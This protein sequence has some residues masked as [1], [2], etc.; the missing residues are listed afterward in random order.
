MMENYD[1][2]YWS[3]PCP[4]VDC[5]RK[6][7][8]CGLEYVFLPAVLGDDSEDSKVAPKKGDYC[9]ALVQYEANNHIYVYT[10][11]GIPVKIEEDAGNI[12]FDDI[13]HRPKY[14]GHSMESSTNIPKVPT[15]TSDLTNDSDYQTSTDVAD[16]V[17]T[18]ATARQN[19]DTAIE[20]KLD[21]TVMADLNVDSNQST[22]VVQLD[23]DKVNLKTGAASTKNIPL[24][25]A[26]SA[27]AGVMNSATFD[28]ISDN[29]NNINALMNGAVA[30][31]GLG[32]T[33]TQAEL[34]TAWQN[35]TGLSTLINRASIYD[36]TNNKVWTYYSNDTTWHESNNTSQVTINTFTN[37]SEG[38]IK[39]STS[40][41]Q[42]F[43]ESNG[44]GSVN[45]WDTLS[46]A[47]ADNTANKLASAN[48]TVGNGLVATTTGTGSSTAID[49]AF[50]DKAVNTNIWTA[51]NLSPATDDLA[52]W[53]AIFGT[54]KATYWTAYSQENCFTNQP[55]KYGYLETVITPTEIY[56]RWHVQPTGG[57]FYRSGNATNG[58]FGNNETG[59]FRPLDASGW[60]EPTS[61]TSYFRRTNW[62]K[63]WDY[64]K[65]GTPVVDYVGG[66]YNSPANNNYGFEV[67]NY[68]LGGD[69]ISGAENITHFRGG[70]LYVPTNIRNASIGVRGLA[71]NS[72]AYLYCYSGYNTTDG[73]SLTPFSNTINTGD[74][75]IASP[76]PIGSRQDQNTFSVEFQ[77]VR[78]TN[79]WWHITGTI[80]GQ[81]VVADFG[82]NCLAQGAGAV[83]GIYFTGAAN[84]LPVVA[85]S[86]FE[87]DEPIND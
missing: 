79:N 8:K 53:Q 69:I 28:A 65:N 11:E 78:N 24:P 83:P 30:V 77:G 33:P 2:T 21:R 27:Q 81:R 36:V 43:A 58:W 72:N 12:S 17:S 25:V 10:K 85:G 38:V 55:S 42:V 63:V 19:A 73:T 20:N 31:T 71:K 57:E 40:V 59:T 7:C 87:I 44:T 5:R 23:A 75:H 34:T 70:C 22:S 16:A 50:A 46:A 15:A 64:Y 86:W 74:T 56:Q 48:L 47:V 41:G 1:K 54:T 52:G 80:Y 32:A 62:V 49:I 37:S 9:N 6:A 51:S 60:K 45:G 68:R 84:N 26:S 4:K 66:T 13:L 3:E 61:S 29:T 35:E 14:D 76:F 39:G 82:I 18:E 67:I